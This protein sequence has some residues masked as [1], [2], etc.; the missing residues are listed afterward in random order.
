MPLL[1]SYPYPAPKPP[2]QNNSWS[3]NQSNPLGQN[4]Q[5]S[6]AQAPKPTT[7]MSALQPAQQTGTYLQAPAPAM[8]MSS[9]NYDG[10]NQNIQEQ[11]PTSLAKGWMAPQQ[12][13]NQN[14]ETPMPQMGQPQQGPSY[15][16]QGFQSPTFD[17]QADPGYQFRL[18]Q[19]LDAVQNRMA[20]RGLISSGAE[21][22]GIM[23]YA[24]G[25]AAQEYQNAYNRFDNDRNYMTDVYRDSRDF[26]Y[27][28]YWDTNKWNYGLFTDERNDW[29][30]RMNGLQTGMNGI[31]NT[32]V[33]ATGNAAD[34]Y[35]NFFNA[36]AGLYG[37]QG[38]VGA[39]QAI[40]GGN[41]NANFLQQLMGLFG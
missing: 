29:N 5:G 9:V 13:P 37:E 4:Y 1:G 36:L 22:T 11:A 2:Q 34:V 12:L 24:S 20:G 32:G 19:G 16:P 30:T 41:T 3:W 18:N 17:F 40:N 27:G 21:Q 31:V 25:L 39:N 15:Q 23:D 33:N 14:F 38:N 6:Y 35:G 26:D 28:N 8:G 7:G 10:Q